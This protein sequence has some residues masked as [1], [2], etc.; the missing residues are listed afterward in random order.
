MI[1][2]SLYASGMTL[3]DIQFHLASTIGT[4]NSHET[5]S[6]IVDEI[7]EEALAWQRRPLAPCIR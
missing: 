5:I 6:K 1:I 3:R 4:E 2:F 7:S